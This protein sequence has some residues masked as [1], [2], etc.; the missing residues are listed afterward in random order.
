[1]VN[2][3]NR[4]FAYLYLKSSPTTT[5]HGAIFFICSEG[6]HYQ[7]LIINLTRIYISFLLFFAV[8]LIPLFASF[9]H[10]CFYPIAILSEII[11]G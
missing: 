5:I 4:I 10:L 9:F 1:M 3:G 7:A 8:L 6:T 11:W 2:E